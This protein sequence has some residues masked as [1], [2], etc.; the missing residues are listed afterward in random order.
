MCHNKHK[1][2]PITVLDANGEVVP[3]TDY[4]VTYKNNRVP[5]KATVM[6]TGKNNVTGSASATFIIKAKGTHIYKAKS[7]TVRTL[8]V[9]L[10]KEYKATGY[11]ILLRKK[12]TKTWKKV[13]TKKL[14]KTIKKLAH[15]KYYYVK[16]RTYK[17]IGGK[18]YYSGY[19]ATKKVRIR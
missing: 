13:F 12:G 10:R 4:T 2:T 17:T 14:T 6:I 7:S 18:K 19:T 9:R 1:K 3:S 11:Q 16:A 8:K 15:K 5:G